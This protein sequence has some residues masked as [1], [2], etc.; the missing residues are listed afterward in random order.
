[1]FLCT[2][3]LAVTACIDPDALYKQV[4]CV[5]LGFVGFIVLT[6]ILS[7]QSLTLKLR[8][9]AAAVALGLL[10]ATLLFGTAYNGSKNWLHLGPISFQPSEFA[11]AAYVFAG[12]SPLFLTD[13]KPGR[14]LW[15][16]AF[17]A[18]CMGALAIMYD[19]GAV[20]IFFVAM[21]V[22][23]LMRLTDVRIVGG[24]T[25]LAA[26]AAAVLVILFPYIG[27]RFSAW[28][29]VWEFADSTGY[30]QTRTLVAA[31]SGGLLGVGGG[32]GISI[33]SSPPIPISFSGSSARN[34]A[35]SSRCALRPALSGLAFT[36]SA[37]AGMPNRLTMPSPC[38]PRPA[39]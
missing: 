9:A 17:S 22:I 25:L 5:F 10:F 38:A 7:N 34:G 8:P 35:A 39:S 16:F 26:G 13:L 32:N 14:R 29:H 20:A 33:M 19:F 2:L 21:I 18:A 6:L 23:L 27:Q 24:I 28:T 36:Q 31:A 37:F 11:K 3:G 30:Q 12:A 4:V 1:M 15:F